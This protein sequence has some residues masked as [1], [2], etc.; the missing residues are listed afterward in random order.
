MQK[1]VAVLL[2]LGSLISLSIAQTTLPV[3]VAPLGSVDLTAA[4]RPCESLAYDF[5]GR[6]GNVGNLC[7]AATLVDA[8]WALYVAGFSGGFWDEITA[9]TSKGTCD[10]AAAAVTPAT[11]RPA[12]LLMCSFVDNVATACG[13]CERLSCVTD[14]VNGNFT[15][16]N[17]LPSSCNVL[18]Q[19]MCTSLQAAVGTACVAAMAPANLPTK[20]DGATGNIVYATTVRQA[21]VA[22]TCRAAPARPP[23]APSSAYI[24]TGTTG[25]FLAAIISCIVSSL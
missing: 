14:S 2:F 25:I 18:P 22:N 3:N 21:C 19:R 16:Q 6:Y 5:A 8:P 11:N 1:L 24:A 10:T 23:P 7:S 13:G 17:H 9:T 15:F 4:E 20:P 12:A